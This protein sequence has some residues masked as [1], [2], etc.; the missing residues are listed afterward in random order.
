MNDNGYIK[1]LDGVRAI[2]ILLV[3]TFHTGITH[4]G[5]IGVQL[6]FVLS[7][8]LITGILWKEKFKT[9]TLSYKFKKFWVRRSLRIFPLYFGYLAFWGITYLCFHFPSYY[10]T[11]FP[12][13]VT[14]TFNYARTLPAWHGNPLFTHLW[15]LSIEEQFYLFFP[16]IVF[17]CPPR[18]LKSF[19]VLVIIMAPL[20][21]FLLG[22]YYRSKG[23]PGDIAGDAIYQ[24]TLSHL[25]AFFM[26]GIIPVLSLNTRFKKPHILFITVFIVVALAG[27]WD[28]AHT[29]H[30]GT[31]YFLDLG[32]NHALVSN[33][34]Y[35]WHYSCLNALF[36][37][38]LLMLVSIHSS[39]RFSLLRKILE[40]K[41]MVRIGRVS[42]GMY[43]FHWAILVYVFAKFFP[44]HSLAGQI[45]LF[46]P[47]TV[48]VYLLA[49]LSYK[50]YES[51]FLKLK[52]KLFNGR[53][54]KTKGIPQI[55][56]SSN[57]IP[58]LKEAQD[59][60]L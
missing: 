23:F 19:M 12:Y 45:L 9:E 57:L 20:I 38:F 52:D 42:Y 49:Q 35:I 34:E 5:W 31:N 17:L 27:L 24:N 1:S 39:Q 58:F 3:M 30:P 53:E 26:G 37:S 10:H 50:I 6:F 7:G 44:V 48:A 41:W 60:S 40:N 46:I 16:F 8:F 4:F 2:A 56:V 11:Y 51:K 25:D 54:D 15:S 21:R 22:E 13:L 43:I 36:A 18:L 28:F 47:Y 59:E 14:Y 55:Q 29:L 33:Y 32:F